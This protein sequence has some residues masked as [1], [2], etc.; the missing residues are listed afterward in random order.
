MSGS[1]ALEDY[2]LDSDIDIHLVSQDFQ[3]TRFPSRGA[4]MLKYWDLDLGDPEFILYTPREFPLMKN[5]MTMVRGRLE[6]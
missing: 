2:L 6:A 5:K 1:R 3:G 4:E